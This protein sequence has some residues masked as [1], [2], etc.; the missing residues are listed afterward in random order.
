MDK[1]CN[2]HNTPSRATQSVALLPTLP[3]EQHL[4]CLVWAGA[5]LACSTPQCPC[6]GC[7]MREGCPL[8]ACSLQVCQ[9]QPR[10]PPDLCCREGAPYQFIA[11]CGDCGHV[12]QVLVADLHRQLLQL[13]HQARHRLL[14]AP[15]Q[16]RAAQS[17]SST[18]SFAYHS[19]LSALH[20]QLLQLIQVLCNTTAKAADF[21]RPTHSLPCR[22]INIYQV[23]FGP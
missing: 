23:P 8:E 22:I 10:N 20:H 6:F 1:G 15:R 2:Q 19:Q 14:N 16:L 21:E 11:S 4:P 5:L 18:T 9:G 12:G 13:V 3:P 7:C 17:R